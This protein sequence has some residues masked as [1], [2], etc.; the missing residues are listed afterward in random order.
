[1]RTK[2]RLSRRLLSNLTSNLWMRTHC[3]RGTLTSRCLPSNRPLRSLAPELR[4]RTQ[5]S[6]YK[7]LLSSTNISRKISNNQP[8]VLLW[9]MMR[10][11]F[12][13]WSSLRMIWSR[14][15]LVKWMMAT[16]TPL[17]ILSL[18]KLTLS[19]TT[20]SITSLAQGPTFLSRLWLTRWT[21]SRPSSRSTNMVLSR[22]VWTLRST[23]MTRLRKL[24]T[25]TI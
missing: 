23:S 12:P 10:K 4:V 16:R 18:L 11:Q 14:G 6:P 24:L 21:S 5:V 1:M 9:S 17:D 15:S 13:E 3:Q 19:W 20:S 22:E 25:S 8:L 2:I 7:N